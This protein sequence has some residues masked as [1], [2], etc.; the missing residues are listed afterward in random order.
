MILDYLHYAVSNLFH[1]RMR[2][3]LTMVGIFIGIAA[4]VALISLG[5][6]LKNSID[7]QFQKLGT[8]KLFVMPKGG[9]GQAVPAFLYRADTD[10]IKKTIGVTSAIGMPFST[11]KLVWHDKPYFG[12][13]YGVPMKDGLA[14]YNEVFSYAAV[15]GRLLR[16]GDTTKAVVGFGLTT[17]QVPHPVRIGDKITVRGT[18]LDVVGVYEKIGDPTNDYGVYVP[19]DTFRQITNTPERVDQIVVKIAKGADAKAVAERVT[20][21]LRKH[22]ALAEGKEDF[23]VQTPDDLLAI[24]NTVLNIVLTVLVGIAAISLLVGGIGIM[25]TMYTAVVERTRE[26]GIMK[27]IGARN[28]DIFLIFLFE[29]GMLGVVGGIIG[30]VL[31]MGASKAVE[32]AVGIF[33]GPHYLSISFQPWLVFGAIAFSFFVGALSGVTPAWQA[34]KMKP[35]DALMYG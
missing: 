31:G 27:S 18:A 5:Q 24:F 2:T 15:Q 14:L 30:V 3:W 4:V 23:T 26:I 33:L 25:N 28:K 16:N 22:R 32:L 17:D 19:E 29:S 35:V 12:Y 10:V 1:K 13:M 21:E 6:G 20:K 11:E 9:F 8:D 34:S 7:D